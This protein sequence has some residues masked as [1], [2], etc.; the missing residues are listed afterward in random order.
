MSLQTGC[1]A[2]DASSTSRD[3]KRFCSCSEFP[4]HLAATTSDSGD[5][6]VATDSEN[7]SIFRFCSCSDLPPHLATSSAVSDAS[8]RIRREDEQSDVADDS[9]QGVCREGA[10]PTRGLL[11]LLPEEKEIRSEQLDAGGG[12]ELVFTDRRVILKG[13]AESRSIFSSMRVDEIET[14]ALFRVPGGR[15]ALYWSIIGA[16]A[17]VAMWQ[18]LDGIGN[19]RLIITALVAV[20]SV[21]MLVLHLVQ[22]S[23]VLLTFRSIY[24]SELSAEFTHSK[25]DDAE[26]F[27]TQVLWR[28][29]DIRSKRNSTHTE[30]SL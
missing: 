23:N 18:S 19:L 14:V 20:V 15:S 12:G 1:N 26:K 29:E 21:G 22:P 6:C 10:E 7:E 24:G 27:A 5:S 13:G 9:S 2:I 3:S 4:S 8:N 28:V 30:S 11:D 25:L 17:S 16:I